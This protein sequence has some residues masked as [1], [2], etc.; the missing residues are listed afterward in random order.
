MVQPPK[1][2]AA[3]QTDI[4]SEYQNAASSEITSN[5]FQRR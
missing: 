4:Q 1:N 2:K 5:D 3:N